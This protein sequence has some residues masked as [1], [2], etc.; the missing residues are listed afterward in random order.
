VKNLLLFHHDPD[1]SDKMV[2]AILTQARQKGG[3]V[4]AAAEGM[5]MTMGSPGAAVALPSTRTGQRRRTH[6][7]AMVEGYSEDGAPFS[8]QTIIHDLSLQGAFLYMTHCPRLQSEVRVKMEANLG[9]ADGS[10]LIW[11]KGY[12]V[13]RE[14]GPQ[15]HTTGVGL[16]FTSEIDIEP[17]EE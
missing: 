11:M 4:W 5:I 9:D 7:P 16:V 3:N 1:S 6:F 15:P 17:P 10:G 2:D 12:V 13:R 14:A 8:E